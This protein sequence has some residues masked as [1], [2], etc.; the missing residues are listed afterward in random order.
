MKLTTNHQ[1][2]KPLFGLISKFHNTRRYIVM[3]ETSVKKLSISYKMYTKK[4]VYR[5]RVMQSGNA[6]AKVKILYLFL[7]IP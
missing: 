7:K 2:T 5:D 3:N 6:E 4:I 1:T